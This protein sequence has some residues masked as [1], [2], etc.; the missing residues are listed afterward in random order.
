[1]CNPS[2]EVRQFGIRLQRKGD[3]TFPDMNILVWE[4]GGVTF[5][6][7]LELDIVSDGIDESESLKTLAE[8]IIEQS[9]LAEKN[10]TQI[11]HPAPKAYW[12]K[13]WELHT[14]RVKQNLADHPP[15][16]SREVLNGLRAVHA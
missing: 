16:S 4:E 8:L 14:N 10:N 6:H 13:L 9:E 7:C 1:M 2:S 12:D 15:R 11:F 3:A 5:A